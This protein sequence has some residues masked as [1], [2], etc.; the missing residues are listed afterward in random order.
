MKT[1]GFILGGLLGILLM[2]GTCLYVIGEHPTVAKLTAGPSFIM[3]G[4]GQLASFTVY[5]PR[6]GNRIAFA[7]EDDSTV[8][9]K[10]VATNGY[11]KGTTVGGLVIQYGRVPAGYS[12]LVP[13]ES[14]VAPALPIGAVYSFFA[15]TTNA[16]GAGG[17]FYMDEKGP[18][19]TFI[20]GL[21]LTLKDG[22]HVR[23]KCGFV[24]DRTYREPTNLV[25]VVRKHQLR[26]T[27]EAEK[28]IEAE[29]SEPCKA[30]SK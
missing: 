30:T 21:C 13:N 11:F 10:I 5:A 15:E 26:D 24:G 20:P 22:H 7:H 25:E 16:P 12:Q 29:F 14:Q 8:V 6:P 3:T 4:N 2:M 19:L 23:V 9:W 27:S 18:I 1:A 17:Y 28:L